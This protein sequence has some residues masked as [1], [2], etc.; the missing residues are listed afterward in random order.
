MLISVQSLNL[1][2][3]HKT[4]FREAGFLLQPRAKCG[5]VGPN[6]SGKTTLLKLL[7]GLAEADQ[8]V[9]ERRPGLKTGYLP[10]ECIVTS[11]QTVV[12]EVESAAAE[13]ITARRVHQE[14]SDALAHADHGTEAYLKLVEA[15]AET[16]RLLEDLE[17]HKLRPKAEKILFG[18]GFTETDM[19]RCC[20]TFS[21]GWQMRIALARL[22]MEEPDLL[23][24]DE[25]TN[26]LDMDSVRWLEA[27]L[28]SYG[29][30]LLLISHDRM[31]LDRLCTEILSIEGG[32]LVPYT[33]N[34]TSFVDQRTA[35]MEML[36]QAKRSQDRKLAKTEAFIDRFRYKATKA[37]QVQ[38]R[39]KQLAKVER[40]ELEEAYKSISFTFPESRK[41]GS[42]VLV[43][44]GLAKAYGPVKVFKNLNLTL[45]RGDRVAVVGRNGAGKS[46]LSRLLGG[47]ESPDAGHIKLGHQ[48]DLNYFAQDQSRELDPEL[49]VL[50]AA[51]QPP[52]AAG[53]T[54][55]RSILGAFLFSGQDVDKRVAVLSGGE[56]NRLAL[57]RMLL[58]P[59]NFIILDEPTNHLDMTSKAVLQDALL[60]FEGTVFL[61][62]H[63]RDFIKP[64]ATRILEL[65]DGG[66]VLHPGSLDDFLWKK[67][68]E[69]KAESSR[70]GSGGRGRITATDKGDSDDRA[71]ATDNENPRERRR[72]QARKLERLAPVKRRIE[73]LEAEIAALEERIAAFEQQ[74]TDKQFFE[75]GTETAAQIRE[76]ET[77]KSLLQDKMETW[78]AAGEELAR[79]EQED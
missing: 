34:Y 56:K 36:E 35:R 45:N 14:Q 47:I 67:D 8:C 46:T 7:N 25:P 27:F 55:V 12:A 1:A 63:D 37:T 38:S 5:L 73:A 29:G 6:G 74:M 66:A 51:S 69:A 53:D 30:S 13:I 21:G 18:L 68:Q 22:L 32:K 50:Q 11:T 75:R 52:V 4:L 20:D 77:C 48:I 39:I 19:E 10:Q 23:M 64:F 15:Y 28:G 72:R 43:A 3:G 42:T 17:A 60:S 41:G 33:G 78:E 54:A 79:I 76:Y 65:K 16:T 61:V 26:H 57:A 71:I 58:C 70:V 62:S 2:Y 24:L 40:I 49:T 9:I 31:L 59:A 44:E